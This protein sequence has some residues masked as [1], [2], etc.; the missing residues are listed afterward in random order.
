MRYLISHRGNINGKEV[1]KE[2]SPE[3]IQNALDLNFDVEIDVW[4]VGES[5]Y[6][7][8]DEPQYLIDFNWLF[9]RQEKLWIHCKSLE[10]LTFFNLNS[11]SYNYFFHDQDAATLTSKGFI[12]AY[13]GKQP[14]LNSIAVLPET[15]NDDLSKC[16]G[17]CSDFIQKFTR[18]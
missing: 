6:L 17:V 1:S 7:G 2:N 4:R 13:P 16:I 9:E 8:H 5:I 3:F 14:V 15:N 18:K 12:W 10:T 11:N